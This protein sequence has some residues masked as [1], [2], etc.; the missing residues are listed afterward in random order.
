MPKRKRRSDYFLK[1]PT[2][3]TKS[4]AV[5]PL[6]VLSLR[7]AERQKRKGNGLFVGQAPPIS[8]SSESSDAVP[9][10]GP[11]EKR[12]CQLSGMAPKTLWGLFDRVNLLNYFPGKKPRAAKHASPDYKKHQSDGDV[13]PIGDAERKA[14]EIDL[15][16]YDTVCLLGLKVARAFKI[17]S[18]SLFKTV[19]LHHDD[20]SEKSNFVSGKACS[21]CNS[22]SKTTTIAIFPHPSG[23][24]HFWNK[25][26]NRIKA[27]TFLKDIISLTL[28]RRRMKKRK[29]INN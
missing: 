10:K 27:S 20:D 23:V 7:V 5:S 29:I 3:R 21:S 2:S 17:P 13:F 8:K 6:D 18:P 25:E 14:Q 15:K 19:H 11:P 22:N 12:L 9:L 1:S 24:S 28:E 4:R 16:A 26:E